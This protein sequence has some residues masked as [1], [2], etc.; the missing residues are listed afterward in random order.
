[1]LAESCTHSYLLVSCVLLGVGTAGGFIG[2]LVDSVLGATI[3]ESRVDEK[4]GVV[5]SEFAEGAKGKLVSGI[6]VLNNNQVNFVSSCITSTC[7]VVVAS[8]YLLSI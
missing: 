2:S 4:T 7:M 1:M 8:L 5:V 3:Q 6:A